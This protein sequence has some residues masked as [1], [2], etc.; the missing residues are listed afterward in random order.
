LGADIGR[1]TAHVKVAKNIAQ[2][3]SVLGGQ[4]LKWIRGVGALDSTN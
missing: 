4:Q 2:F 3:N 1:L